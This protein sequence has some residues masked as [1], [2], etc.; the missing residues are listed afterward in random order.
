MPNTGENVW[1]PASTFDE[2]DVDFAAFLN[3]QDTNKAHGLLAEH[4]IMDFEKMV[5][6]GLATVH[7]S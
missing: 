2:E 5:K 4:G 3:D 6:D 1:V 7:K